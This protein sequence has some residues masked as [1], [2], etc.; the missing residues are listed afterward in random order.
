LSF[1][2]PNEEE[3]QVSVVE[4][5]E[6]AKVFLARR[7][8]LEGETIKAISPRKFKLGMLSRLP[9]E[10]MTPFL[11]AWDEQVEPLIR[12]KP[13]KELEGGGDGK[14]AKTTRVE[15]V[16]QKGLRS[17]SL[18]E[19]E[20]EERPRRT[21]TEPSFHSAATKRKRKERSLE[22]EESRRIRKEARAHYA[23]RSRASGEGDTSEVRREDK[24]KGGASAD[25]RFPEGIKTMED[26]VAYLQ[27]KLRQLPS[28]PVLVAD[29][30]RRYAQID[31]AKKGLYQ[32]TGL[33]IRVN[34]APVEWQ[35]V[36]LLDLVYGMFIVA[37]NGLL[38]TSKT[39]C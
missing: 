14:L 7:S 30:E 33:M 36:L 38:N 29:V 8:D 10:K 26:F 1:K 28:N 6:E 3:V 34:K 24:R 18:G 12:G 2:G 21:T 4:L 5:D 20:G 23:Q 37:V 15:R 19:P 9:S 31:Q 25:F 22:Q 27:P 35:R 13:G 16:A 32:T 39:L 17:L 11:A